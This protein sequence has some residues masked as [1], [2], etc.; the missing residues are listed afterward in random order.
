MSTPTS[1]HAF[2]GDARVPYSV[3]PHRTAF[4]TQVEEASRARNW[5]K[6]V[7]CIADGKPIQAVFPATLIVNL[8]RLLALTGA[9]SIRFALEEESC[10]LVPDCESGAIPPFGPLYG[11]PVFVD[12]A[13]AAELEVAFNAGTYREAIRMRYADL[14]A[15]TRPTVGRFAECPD[16]QGRETV[17]RP[18]NWRAMFRGTSRE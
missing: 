4:E 7:I 10:L 15:A 9:S 17:R 12:T 11:Q 3:V 14:A 18:A 1:I 5:A 2:L 16:Q 8:D 6:V 13:L